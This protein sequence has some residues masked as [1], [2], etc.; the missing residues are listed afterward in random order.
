MLQTLEELFKKKSKSSSFSEPIYTGCSSFHWLVLA[1]CEQRLIWV[2]VLNNNRKMLSCI[3]CWQGHVDEKRVVMGSM[4]MN[5]ITNIIIWFILFVL[6][7]FVI[8]L[9]VIAIAISQYQEK[10][11]HPHQF[12]CLYIEPDDPRGLFLWE[13]KISHFFCRGA[14]WGVREAGWKHG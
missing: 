12:L 9:I 5:I 3:K 6:L 13:Q 1:Q 11:W 10:K 2:S 14:G 7:Y 4:D 8:V